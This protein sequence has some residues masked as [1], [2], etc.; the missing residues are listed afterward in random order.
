MTKNAKKIE[1]I[2]PEVVDESSEGSRVPLITGDRAILNPEVLLFATLVGQGEGLS[3]AYRKAFPG[4]AQRHRLDVYAYQLAKNPKVREQISIIQEAVR[5]QIITEA[6]AAFERIRE[7]A[8]G[9]QH[10]KIRLDA[11]RDI[12]DRAGLK[13]PQKVESLHVGLWGSLSQEDVRNMIRNKL[14]NN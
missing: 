1:V 3:S 8:E 10:E 11:N 4:K 9:A 5:L 6:P 12:L 14:E 2:E 7:L 13:P